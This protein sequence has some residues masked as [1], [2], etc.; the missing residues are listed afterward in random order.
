MTPIV[1]AMPMPFPT[2]ASHAALLLALSSARPATAAAQARDLG[3]DFLLDGELARGGR[4]RGKKATL[5]LC[6]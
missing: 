4:L 6:R 2:R 5:M 3:D 1:P